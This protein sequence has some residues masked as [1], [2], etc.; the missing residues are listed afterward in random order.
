M[1]KTKS[2]K[3]TSKTSKVEKVT[4]EQLQTIRKYNEDLS[5]I[6][7][8][9]ASLELSKHALL[10]QFDTLNEG[11]QKFTKELEAEYGQVSV[12][13]DDGTIGELPEKED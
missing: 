5:K 1:S 8:S 12:S 2:T 11:F 7:N 13:I 6:N 3:K 9:L 10:K 4:D